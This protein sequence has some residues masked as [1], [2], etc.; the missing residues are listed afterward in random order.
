MAK[1][2]FAAMGQAGLTGRKPPACMARAARL[3]P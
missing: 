1:W 3:R 2:N